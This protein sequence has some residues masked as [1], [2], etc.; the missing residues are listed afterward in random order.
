MHSPSEDQEIIVSMCGVCAA[1]CGVEVHLEH[2]KIE[3]L[4]PLK[5]H[6]QGIVC[7]RGMAA[8]EIVYSKDRILFPQRRVGKRGEGIF[9]RIS[10]DDAYNIIVENLQKIA[11]DFGPE[12][13]C[14]YTG[15]GNFEFGL[16]E[17]L[18]PQRYRRIRRMQCF[19]HSAHQTTTGVGSP[20]VSMA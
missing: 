3:R 20:Y 9:E 17:R 6:P 8:K 18:C 19:S 7:P 15:R 11:R 4:V 10:W 16:Y 14:I 12:A 1:G 13:L 5:N 2:G